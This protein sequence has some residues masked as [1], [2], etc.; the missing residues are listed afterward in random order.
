M[1]DV[2]AEQKEERTGAGAVKGSVFDR[3]SIL[4]VQWTP[5][6]YSKGGVLGRMVMQRG[7]MMKQVLRE[8]VRDPASVLGGAAGVEAADGAPIAAF[9]KWRRIAAA[10]IAMGAEYDE[11]AAA[12]AVVV[13]EEEEDANVADGDQIR[14]VE[15][16]IG[17]FLRE[18]G[19]GGAGGEGD[20]GVEGGGR[21]QEER[22]AGVADADPRKN[23]KLRMHI[24]HFLLSM[25]VFHVLMDLLERALK[26]NKDTLLP[27][28]VKYRKT[29]GQQRYFE[30]RKMTV[31]ARS[32]V[33]NDGGGSDVRCVLCTVT[34]TT[35]VAAVLTTHTHTHTHSPCR[36]ADHLTRSFSSLL[37]FARARGSTYSS[38]GALSG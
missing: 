5:E 32:A 26:L 24:E 12:A 27:F 8:C 34:S 10:A 2:A 16:R 9:G 20:M 35:Y 19:I 3:E 23:K 18:T 37:P 29:P 7:D 6:D 1:E 21:G 14:R 38:S 31:G 17:E 15:E 11:E 33:R 25:G 13:D 4:R 28:I 22:E 30:V 36:N